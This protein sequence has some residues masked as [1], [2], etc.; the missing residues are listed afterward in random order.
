MSSAVDSLVYHCLERMEHDGPAALEALCAEHPEKAGA[1]RQRFE[2]L[3]RAGLLSLP[4]QDERFP[5][6]IGEH[7]LVRRLGAGGMGVVF[8]AEE[9]GGGEVALKILRPEQLF[10]PRSRERFRREVDAVA[11]LSHPGIVAVRSVAED[12]ESP[13]FTMEF[14]RGISLAELIRSVAG[15]A[16]E[17]LTGRDLLVGIEQGGTAS[18]DESSAELLR[19]STMGWA[20]ACLSI[21]AAVAQALVH[22]HGKGVLHRDVKP[23]N[24]MIGANGRV[25]LVDFGL[26]A[27]VGEDRITRTG[28]VLG[29]LPYASPEQLDGGRV[30]ARSDVYSLGVLLFELLSLRLPY[31]FPDPERLRAEIRGGRAPSLCR[32]NPSVSED[33]EVVCRTAMEAD[34]RARYGSMV[35]FAEDLSNLLAL[36]PVH[37]RRVAPLA[38][39]ARWTRRHRAAA[40]AAMLGMV[41]VIGGPISFGF[42]RHRAAQRVELLNVELEAALARGDTNLAATEALM[43][44]LLDFGREIRRVPEL[45]E[46]RVALLLRASEIYLDL[47]GSA[48]TARTERMTYALGHRRVLEAL[49]H[50]GFFSE[51]SEAAARAVDLIRKDL[52]SVEPETGGMG[53]RRQLSI[54]LARFQT[55]AGETLGQLGRGDEALAALREAAGLLEAIHAE[56]GEH[57]YQALFLMAWNRWHQG[58]ALRD[59]GA[60]DAAVVAMEDALALE[61]R[62]IA[63]FPSM[64]YDVSRV[65]NTNNDLGITYLRAGRLDAAGKAFTEAED[66]LETIP[67]ESRTVFQRTE[68]ARAQAGWAAVFLGEGR[69]EEALASVEAALAAGDMLR[70]GDTG[71]SVYAHICTEWRILRA[72]AL[73]RLDRLGEASAPIQ[74]AIGLANELMA[75]EPGVATFAE[76]AGAAW[77][78]QAE[79]QIAGEEVAAARA[80]LARAIE[81]QRKALRA[82]PVEWVQLKLTEYEGRLREL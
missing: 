44:E 80:S 34:P 42:L 53:D 61:R 67:P 37:A 51:S 12:A 19:L 36:R 6:R 5:E 54:L 74:E 15:K 31:P 16:P 77:A 52:D 65:A 49:I 46:R 18:P 4:P 69:A 82:R 13:Y 57:E 76:L 47:A 38:R 10:F 2:F 72:E 73:R 59:G 7:R 25:Q 21:V 24:V 40:A 60:F 68:G 33:V 26:A 30:D 27:L 20:E 70:G 28:A 75:I 71:E 66:L 56:G 22:A 23:S 78:E 29:S 39:L 3:R 35:E 41:V 8:L 55:M 64:G 17:F 79:L 11:R 50:L 45:R 62:I 58:K 48:G 43:A 9:P 1:V 32:L 63:E 81:A 14:V